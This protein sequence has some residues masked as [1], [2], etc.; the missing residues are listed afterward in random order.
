MNKEEL[1]ITNKLIEQFGIN[2]ATFNS[3]AQYIKSNIND[4]ELTLVIERAEE[5][6][7]EYFLFLFSEKHSHIIFSGYKAKDNLI[8]NI[9]GS[10]KGYKIYKILKDHFEFIGQR[11]EGQT[12]RII[13]TDK[14]ITIEVHFGI[15]LIWV[16]IYYVANKP[17]IFE[18]NYD[19][20]KDLIDYFK[21]LLVS[22]E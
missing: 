10:L 17:H 9:L 21:L 22:Y 4:T 1:N 3:S 19:S 2:E 12:Q 15:T 14:E 16:N 8:K 5:Y 18:Y 20:I 7:A 11:D 13:I 6:K